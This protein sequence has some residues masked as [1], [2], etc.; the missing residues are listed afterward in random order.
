MRRR[1]VG[2]GEKGRPTVFD[3][4]PIPVDL[5][6]GDMLTMIARS[7]RRAVSINNR[8]VKRGGG[9]DGRSAWGAH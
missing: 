6:R 1:S 4:E 5:A 9:R 8:E 3:R 2:S 7:L